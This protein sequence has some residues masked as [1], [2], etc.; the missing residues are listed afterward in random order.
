MKRDDSGQSTVEYILILLITVGLALLVLRDLVKP[1]YDRLTAWV[2]S[3]MQAGLFKPE[4][5]HRLNLK[6]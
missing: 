2:S 3:Q 1:T 5:F 4:N 6:H